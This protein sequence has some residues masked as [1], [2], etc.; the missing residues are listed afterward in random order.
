MRRAVRRERRIDLAAGIVRMGNREDRRDPVVEID[1]VA[2]CEFVQLPQ[3]CIVE[4]TAAQA[5]QGRV[6]RHEIRPLLQTTARIGFGFL[7]AP[8]IHQHQRGCAS[9]CG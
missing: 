4:R 6:H 3:V 2:A 9:I 1:V 8:E 5:A 7:E